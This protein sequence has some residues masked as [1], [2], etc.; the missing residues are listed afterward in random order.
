MHDLE[1]GRSV[2]DEEV[3]QHEQDCRGL[4]TAFYTRYEQ[5]QDQSDRTEALLW[6]RRAREA[7]GCLSQAYK[8]AR[9]AQIQ[10]DIDEGCGYFM[11][12]GD[13]ARARRAGGR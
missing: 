8:D 6:E 3:L 4:S 10:R 7:R 11:D 9:E 1:A 12:Q 5:S 2:S 13:A